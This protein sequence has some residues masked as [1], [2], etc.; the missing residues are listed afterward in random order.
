MKR[1]GYLYYFWIYFSVTGQTVF[2]SNST[3]SGGLSSQ[4]PPPPVEI[5]P[6]VDFSEF[7]RNIAKARKDGILPP[8]LEDM[9]W[10]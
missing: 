5:P 2:E 7:Y 9:L 1:W 6:Y 4:A 10:W 8:E 3:S